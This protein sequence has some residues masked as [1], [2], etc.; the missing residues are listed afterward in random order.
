[1]KCPTAVAFA[2]PALSR[3]LNHCTQFVDPMNPQNESRASLLRSSKSKASAS[4]CGEAINQDSY[5]HLWQK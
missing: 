5:L 3:R 1:M 4:L 2:W